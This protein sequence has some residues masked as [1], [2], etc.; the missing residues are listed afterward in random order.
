MSIKTNSKQAHCK[1]Q[2]DVKTEL[3]SI[4]IDG[5]NKVTQIL[6]EIEFQVR[7]NGEKVIGDIFK[8]YGEPSASSFLNDEW[9]NTAYCWGDCQKNKHWSLTDIM[10][11]GLIVKT[12]EG[13]EGKFNL[14]FTLYDN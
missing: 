2:D 10:G 13:R 4:F 14:N 12:F 7:P 11:K 6:R 8:I 5:N 9:K 3:I 1:K